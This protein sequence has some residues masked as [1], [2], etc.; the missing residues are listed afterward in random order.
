MGRSKLWIDLAMDNGKLFAYIR[1]IRRPP[2]KEQ[3]AECVSWSAKTEAP[4]L[5][6]SQNSV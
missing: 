4:A 3:A 6:R 5:F 1:A 2:T